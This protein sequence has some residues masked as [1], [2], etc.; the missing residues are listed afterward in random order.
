MLRKWLGRSAL[1]LAVCA[2]SLLT[3]ATTITVSTTAAGTTPQY[4]GFSQGDY[5]FNTNT[6]AWVDYSGANA[7]RIWSTPSSYPTEVAG[8]NVTTQSDFEARKAALRADPQSNTYINWPAFTA[9]S[10]STIQVGSNLLTLDYALGQLNGRGIHVMEQMT[11]TVNNEVTDWSGKWSQWQAYYAQAFYDARNY[12]VA[13]FQIYNE[14]DLSTG[15]T[16]ADLLVRLQLASD[17]VH[18]AI[19]DVNALF[20]RHLTASVAGPTSAGSSSTTFNTWGKPLLA[21]NRTGYDGKPTS[22]DLFDTY[23][24]HNYTSNISSFASN[25]SFVKNNVAANN[26]SGSA[27]PVILSEFN[28][29]TSA[30]FANNNDNL[31]MPAIYSGIG[32]DLIAATGAGVDGLYA[33]KFSQTPYDSTAQGTIP[34]PTGFY[35][36]DSGNTDNVTGSTPAAEA[37]RLYA[38]G[39]K[40]GRTR[41]ATS[42]GTTSGSYTMV[43]DV[44]ASTGTY[45]AYAAN[46]ATAANSVTLDLSGWNVQP[47]QLVTLEEVSAR[48]MGEVSAVL[49]VGANRQITFTQPSQSVEL[50]TVQQGAPQRAS[51]VPAAVVAQLR[52]NP[53]IPSSKTTPSG[54]ISTFNVARSTSPTGD[55]YASYV[56]F[57]LT[58]QDRPSIARAILSVTG[59]NSTGSSVDTIEVYG[60]LNDAWE[61]STLTWSTAPDLSPTAPLMTN[62]GDGAFPVGHLSFDATDSTAMIDVTSFLQQFSADALVTFALVREQQYAGEP[63]DGSVAQLSNP[64]LILFSSA[65]PE[66]GAAIA[67]G[68]ALLTLRRR[69]RPPRVRS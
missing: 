14:P 55:N 49:T 40:A 12:N 69:P 10:G 41:L 27:M 45:Y 63:D 2:S 52:Y 36:L 20:G 30:S 61:P 48:R 56:K 28:Y 33:F 6:S 5:A 64:Q 17:A 42:A 26:A 18:S 54:N 58:S 15:E 25:I 21:A 38:K 34:Q 13:Q 19:A 35:Y 7:F 66:P 31:R 11:R 32:A 57:D 46:T 1:T 59:H 9:K 22:Y 3:R 8:V 43:A 50:V 29:Q 4:V 53:S 23:D 44:D 68:L 47:G 62:V 65:T 37:Y 39:F 24:Y 67:I 60:I 16:P 51:S